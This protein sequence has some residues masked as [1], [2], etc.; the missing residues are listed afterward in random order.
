[1]KIKTLLS[2][3]VLLAGAGLAVAQ[4]TTAFTYQGR[5]NDTNGPATGSYDFQ[6]LLCTN[7]SSGP[8]LAGFIAVNAGVVVSNGLFTMQVQFLP[9]PPF[10]TLAL[11]LELS[12]RTNGTGSYTTLSPRQRLT[13]TPYAVYSTSAGS[14]S[15]FAGSISD[16]QLSSNIPR[17]NGPASFNVNVSAVSFSGDGSSL[18]GLNASQLAQGTVP[19]A[20]LSAN[21]PLLN[22][23]NTFTASNVFAGV[24]TGNNPSNRF[25][26]AFTGNFTGN[27]AGLSNVPTASLPAGVA[28]VNSNQTFTASNVLTGVVTALNTTNQFNGAFSGRHY[29]DGSLL[30]GLY[31]DAISFG[32]VPDTRLST[33]VALL[34]TSPK[35]L[36]TLSAPAINIGGGH[37]LSGGAASIAGGVANTNQANWAFIGGG[38]DNTIQSGGVWSVIAGGLGNTI[39]SSAVANIGGG[40]MNT[41]QTDASYASIGG[42]IGNLISNSATYATIPGGINNTV[43]GSYS[44]AAGNYAHAD[45][46]GTFVWADSAGGPFSSTSNNQ[47][48]VRANGGIRLLTGA[49]T[50][51]LNGQ[52]LL[53]GQITSG[54]IASGAIQ[55]GQIASSQVVKSLNGLKDDLAINAGSNVTVAVAGTNIFISASSPAVPSAWLL[56]GN[57]GTAAGVDFLGTTDNQPL[58]LKANGLRALRVEPAAFSPNLTGGSRSNSIASGLNGAVIAGGG[59]D[60][61]AGRGNVISNSGW[62]SFIGA[63]VANRI[64][65][66]HSA[67][68]GGFD[69][70][71]LQ[72][73]GFNGDSSSS[74]YSLIAGGQYNRVANSYLGTLGGGDANWLRNSMA[75]FVGGGSHNRVGEVGLPTTYGAIAGG[76]SNV[77][78]ADAAFIGGGVLNAANGVAATVSGGWSNRVVGTRAVV[79]GGGLNNAALTAWDA[80][81][82]GGYGNSVGSPYTTIGGGIGNTVNSG[83]GTVAGGSGNS[84]VGSFGAIGGGSNNIAG[85]AFA[86]V[87]GGSSN[88]ASGIYSTVAGGGRNEARG[89]ASVI[90]GGRANPPNVVYG[91]WGAILGGWDMVVRGQSAVAVGGGNQSANGNHSMV[92]GGRWNEASGDFSFASGT[93]AKADHRGAFVWADS[94]QGTTNIMGTNYV[95]WPFEFRSTN[96]N[97]FAVRCAGGARFVSGVETNGTP[98]FGVVLYPNATSW[99]SISDRNAKTDFRTV[100]SKAVLE[101]LAQVPVQRWHYKGED[102]Q[103]PLHLGPMAQDF[104]AAF[105]PGRD[106]KTITTLE[107]DGVELAAIQG[108]NQ[109]LEESNRQLR[110]SLQ[111]QDEL[112]A[113]LARRMAELERRLPERSGR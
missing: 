89:Y 99:A 29:G 69:N 68:S 112:L 70:E 110:E 6:S 40:S 41:I 37:T 30:T 36:F 109:K 27:G 103:A 8:P 2:L 25:S 46:L 13:P 19:E 83:S 73:G 45:H 87:G 7:G 101:K 48:N 97:E 106:D 96:Q 80:T 58:E 64:E 61:V 74:G 28:M 76:M 17:V 21:V 53:S 71:L 24:V 20:R 1:M 26:G 88:R 95:L 35:F 11:W 86:T 108:L 54:Q 91:D 14:A 62:F 55:G 32:T 63:G 16:S 49:S 113:D 51:T 81:V 38:R 15:Q 60:T 39:Q 50:A 67:V 56:A 47:F 33:N 111:A 4:G 3:G 85:E 10:A 98:K 9:T 79:G 92:L 75:A 78:T 104:K 18:A 22:S 107:F 93:A 77:V 12:V 65:T 66:I 5:F 52:P 44:F 42:G 43:G 94:V 90:G 72:G 31:G 105:Y 100:D 59:D 57:A 82:G 34:N 23:N 102:G 84:V